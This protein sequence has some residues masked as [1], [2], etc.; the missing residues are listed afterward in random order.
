MAE[1][2]KVNIKDDASA[3]QWLQMVEGINQ[4]YHEAMKDAADCISDMQNFAD[5]TMVDELVNF[6]SSLMTAAN[7]TFDAISVISTTV[8]KI[9]NQVKNFTEDIVGGIKGIAKMFG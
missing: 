2:L 7:K 8:D 1:N 6:A 9:L 5:G 3:R 4:D